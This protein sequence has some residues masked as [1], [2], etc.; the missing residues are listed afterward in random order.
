MQLHAVTGRKNS[1]FCIAFGAR[2][3]PAEKG[4]GFL[5]VAGKL[6]VGAL[7]EQ[8]LRRIIGHAYVDLSYFLGVMLT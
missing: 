7:P 8:I 2:A 5:I 3:R 1:L 4:N 6:Y